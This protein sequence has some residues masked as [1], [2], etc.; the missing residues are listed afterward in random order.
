MNKLLLSIGL[1]MALVSSAFAGLISSNV[2]SGTSVLSSARRQFYQVTVYSTTANLI[3]FYDASNTALTYVTLPYYRSTNLVQS[4][5]SLTTN[6]VF[7]Y[8]IYT[9]SVYSHTTNQY[10]IQTNIYVGGNYRTNILMAQSTN[11][12][13]LA[14]SIVV[15]AGTV[16][17]LSAVDA[18]FINGIAVTATNTATVVIY[19]RD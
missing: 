5:T 9:N 4:V 12:Y 11:Q 16:A 13:P 17:T 8:D 14:Y 6:G 19:T 18:N 2:S 10:L 3:N 1:G 15:P 7:T